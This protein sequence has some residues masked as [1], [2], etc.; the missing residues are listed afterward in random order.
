[1]EKGQKL[2]ETAHTGLLEKLIV[3][4]S[5]ESQ[6]RPSEIHC[7]AA[8]KEGLDRGP[9]IEDARRLQALHKAIDSVTGGEDRA[10]MTGLKSGAREVQRCGRGLA[11]VRARSKKEQKLSHRDPASTLPAPL[12]E[13]KYISR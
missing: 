12:P 10:L 4:D 5:P 7:S 9:N 1:M 2:G 6:A 3:G 13:R 8:G 11:T